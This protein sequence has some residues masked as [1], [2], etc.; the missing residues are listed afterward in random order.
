MPEIAWKFSFFEKF[1]KIHPEGR[2]KRLQFFLRIM[3]IFGFWSV[4]YFSIIHYF[5]STELFFRWIDDFIYD[6]FWYPIYFFFARLFPR[7]YTLLIVFPIYVISAKRMRDIAGNNSPH[8][9]SLLVVIFCILFPI[10]TWYLLSPLI[11][12]YLLRVP[13]KKEENQNDQNS[14]QTKKSLFKSLLGFNFLQ[15]NLSPEIRKYSLY[16]KY[17]KIWPELRIGREQFAVRV[18]WLLLIWFIIFVPL[19]F[20]EWI[21]QVMVRLERET[22]IFHLFIPFIIEYVVGLTFYAIFYKRFRDISLNDSVDFKTLYWIF[23]FILIW[24][25]DLYAYVALLLLVFVYFGSLRGQA[26]NNKNGPDPNN[27]KIS[28]FG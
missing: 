17:F 12:L 9:W 22:G 16:Q 14:E 21:W 28:F 24:I 7:I 1:F 18:T 20:W 19:G 27:D 5:Q 23:I 3:I 2:I 8:S 10:L 6:S 13:G 15:R 11:F 26:W 4:I 25:I